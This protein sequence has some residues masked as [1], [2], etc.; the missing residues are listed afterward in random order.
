MA[1]KVVEVMFFDIDVWGS[2]WTL[3]WNIY[4]QPWNESAIPTLNKSGIHMD[5]IKHYTFSKKKR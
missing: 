5:I 1:A 3:P 2:W 4:P